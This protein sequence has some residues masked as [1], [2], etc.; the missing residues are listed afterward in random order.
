[1]SMN[2]Q[3]Q[4]SPKEQAIEE[5]KQLTQQQ[6]IQDSEMQ[7]ATIIAMKP[8]NDLAKAFGAYRQVTQLIIQNL[9]RQLQEAEATNSKLSEE[10]KSLATQI[11]ALTKTVSKTAT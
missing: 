4:L 2:G 11:A 10:N 7:Q 3:K 6:Q 8:I 1:M 5:L 9:T